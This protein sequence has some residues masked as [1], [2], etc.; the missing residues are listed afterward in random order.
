MDNKKDVNLTK[1]SAL[2]KVY[3]DWDVGEDYEIIKQVGSGSYG[4]VVKAEKKS[5][6]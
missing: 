1:L 5:T 2:P 4:F 3:H 6:G